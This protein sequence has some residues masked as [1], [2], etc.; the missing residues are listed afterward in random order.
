MGLWC[1]T[2][3]ASFWHVGGGSRPRGRPR[4]ALADAGAAEARSPSPAP[5][6]GGR[7]AGQA[8]AGSAWPAIGMIAS[9]PS[10]RWP[11]SSSWWRAGGGDTR[12]RHR[13]QSRRSRHGGADRDRHTRAGSHSGRRD[14]H[15][16][17]RRRDASDALRPAGWTVRTRQARVYARGDGARVVVSVAPR[18]GPRAA[19]ARPRQRDGARRRT[20]D[21]GTA[22]PARGAA[23]GPRHRRGRE[24][25]AFV[26]GTRRSDRARRRRRARAARRPLRARQSSRSRRRARRVGSGSL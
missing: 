7:N 22:R 20:A 3:R 21:G 9:P 8:S 2:C 6:P 4:A 15:A 19:A 14:D 11:S 25:T 23:G 18:T 5:A 13:R 24:V 10:P 26:L 12:R 17:H 16:P 1:P